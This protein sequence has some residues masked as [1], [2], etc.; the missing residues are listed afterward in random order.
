MNVDAEVYGYYV[1]GLIKFT[2]L[3]AIANYKR[4][5]TTG[6][7]KNVDFTQILDNGHAWGIGIEIPLSEAA[8]R[9]EKD[10]ILR[11]ERTKHSNVDKAIFRV[12]IS[13]PFSF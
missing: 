8:N 12:S 1:G 7:G 13:R 11:L 4:F 10:F 3:R 2:A 5:Y 6:E 9:N